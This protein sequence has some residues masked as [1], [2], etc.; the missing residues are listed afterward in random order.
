VSTRKHIYCQPT[1][2]SWRLLTH[3]LAV[4]LIW[5]M[6]S[7]RLVKERQVEGD[8]SEASLRSGLS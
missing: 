7:D 6:N 1:Q 4:G 8:Y 2:V 5:P 3:G